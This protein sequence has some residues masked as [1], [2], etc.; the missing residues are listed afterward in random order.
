ML[1][2]SYLHVTLMRILYHRILVSLIANNRLSVDPVQAHTKIDKNP[3]FRPILDE[4]DISRTLIQ[5]K[6]MGWWCK[7]AEKNDEQSHDVYL[8]AK[9][10]HASTHFDCF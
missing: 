10:V 9:P 4:S 6:S 5:I 2:Y 3:S 1:Y 8:I 7:Q